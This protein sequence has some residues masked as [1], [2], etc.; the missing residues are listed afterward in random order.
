LEALARGWVDFACRDVA[1]VGS[2][3]DFGGGGT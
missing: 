1:F 3:I 2:G